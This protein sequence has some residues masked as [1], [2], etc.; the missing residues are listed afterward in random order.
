MGN[1]YPDGKNVSLPRYKSGLGAEKFMIKNF[2]NKKGLMEKSDFKEH[3]PIKGNFK[4][5]KLKKSLILSIYKSSALNPETITETK[6][7]AK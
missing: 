1:P 3:Q 7:N 6:S 2:V 4:S 5:P